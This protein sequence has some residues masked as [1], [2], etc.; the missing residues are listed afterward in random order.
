[1]VHV[2]EGARAVVSVRVPGMP[3]AAALANPTQRGTAL[4]SVIDQLR[5]LRALD[6]SDVAVM[7]AVGY[8]RE[9]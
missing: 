3:L 1:M 6:P 5:T 8:A 9:T 4:A 7:D 2:D